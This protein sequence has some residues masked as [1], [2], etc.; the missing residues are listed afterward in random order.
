MPRTPPALPAPTVASTLAA[1]AA[2]AG[3]PSGTTEVATF[4]SGCFWGT[5]HIFR[6]YYEGRGLVNASVGYTGGDLKDPS[7][8]RVCGGDTGHAEACRIEFDPGLVAYAELVE[9]FY[10]S[11]DP[12]TLNRQGNDSGTQYRSAI[13]YRTPAQK[14][15]AELVT[16][17]V[18]E[19]H[20]APRGKHIVTQIVEAGEWWNAEDYHQEYLD[21]NPDGYQ[22]STHRIWF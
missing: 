16:R 5:E 3:Q 10:R 11:H 13:F 15:A 19:K 2:L 1:H 4:A 14:A 8:R 12:T 21:K 17:E 6:Q 18:E 7:Y 20:F 9:F 22:C